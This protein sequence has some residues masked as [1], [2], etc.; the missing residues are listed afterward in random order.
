MYPG[1]MYPLPQ[2]NPGGSRTLL[3]QVSLTPSSS[4]YQN[5]GVQ[6]PTIPGQVDMWKNADV[7]RSDVPLLQSNLVVQNPT[8]PWSV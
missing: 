7:P 1:Q 3:H 4:F 6:S 2:L 5:L 8:T